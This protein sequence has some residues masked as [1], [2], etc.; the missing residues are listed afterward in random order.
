MND[1]VIMVAQS[2]NLRVYGAMHNS[3]FIH[4]R[5]AGPL[6]GRPAVRLFRLVPVWVVYQFGIT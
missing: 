1:A 5:G 6:P 2:S 3:S 4:W